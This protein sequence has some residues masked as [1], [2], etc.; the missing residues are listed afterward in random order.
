MKLTKFEVDLMPKSYMFNLNGT[1]NILNDLLV[2]N[3]SSTAKRRGVEFIDYRSYNYD[4]DATKI[5]WKATLRAQ[6]LLV[7]ETIEEKAL[8]VI[9]FFDVSDSMLCSST[10]KLKCEYAA[11]FI[12][13]LAH[14]IQREGNAIGLYM[15]N[16]SVVKMFHP[17]IGI[18]QYV[19][20]IKEL[21][22]VNNYGG[23]G[24]MSNSLKLARDIL[25]ES[26]LI[27]LI[28]DFYSMDEDTKNY[29]RVLS[30]RYGLVGINI[31][32]P[33]DLSLPKDAGYF[34]LEDPSSRKSI[35]VDTIEYY[36][37]YKKIVKEQSD[38]LNKIFTGAKASLLTL[39]TNTDFLKPL[40]GFFQKGINT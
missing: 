3:F 31:K 39:S 27:I 35:I 33:N 7:K 29:L 6:K 15:F 38:E 11:Q 18:S 20:I 1:K 22:N 36:E 21:K 37:E 19:K 10:D 16:E 24:N 14:A 2:G 13:T 28:S 12:S 4:D 8:N 25:N 40:A 5:D 26:A 30:M 17:A 34:T 32:D 23:K 9:F